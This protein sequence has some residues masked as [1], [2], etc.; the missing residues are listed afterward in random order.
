MKIVAPLSNTDSYE[1]LVEAG[2]D[3]FFAGMYQYNG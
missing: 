3:E 1:K 2:A